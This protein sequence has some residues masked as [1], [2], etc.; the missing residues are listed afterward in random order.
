MSIGRHSQ[1]EIIAALKQM[2]AGRKA[3]EVAREV[4]VPKHPDSI[5]VQAESRYFLLLV[6]TKGGTTSTDPAQPREKLLSRTPRAIR[7]R[8]KSV[9]N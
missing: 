3:E 7:S 6:S 4:G 5:R 8:L 1:A 9:S 2:D